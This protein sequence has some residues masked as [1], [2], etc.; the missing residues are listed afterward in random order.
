MC[1]AHRLRAVII[2]A[3]AILHPEMAEAEQLR[4]ECSI[5]TE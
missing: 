3:L 5:K 4:L 2:T 1:K